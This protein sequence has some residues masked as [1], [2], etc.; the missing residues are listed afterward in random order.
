MVGTGDDGKVSVEEGRNIADGVFVGVKQTADGPKGRVEVELTDSIRVEA[1]VG[2]SGAP[3]VG[4][5]F[6]LDY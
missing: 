4:V 1:G 6:E 2:A 5:G 3:E